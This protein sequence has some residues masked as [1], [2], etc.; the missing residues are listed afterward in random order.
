MRCRRNKFT[1]YKCRVCGD[2]FDFSPKVCDPVETMILL[3]FLRQ[4][5]WKLRVGD[6]NIKKCETRF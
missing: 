3:R 5:E 6:G 1:I 4:S 2:D